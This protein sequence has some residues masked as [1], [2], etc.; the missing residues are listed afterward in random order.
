MATSAGIFPGRW[1]LYGATGYTGRLVAA[2]AVARGLPPILAGR[3]GG[4]LT[5]L[6]EQLGLPVRVFPLDEPA[7]LYAALEGVEAVLHCAGPFVWTSRPMVE[8]CLARGVHYLDVT[9]EIPVFEAILARGEEARQRGV[10]LLPGV[11]FDVVPTDCLAATLAAALP[12]GHRLELAFASSRAGWSA[13]TLKTMLE[14]LPAGGAERRDG[15][16][17][18]VRPAALTR[19]INFSHRR[20]MGVSIPWGDVSTAYHTTG[21]PNVRVYLGLPTRAALRLRRLVTLAPL[22][23]WSALRRFLQW[24]VG[25]TVQG[26]DEAARSDGRSYVWGEVRRSDGS[27]VQARLVAP[28][29]YALTAVAAVECLRRTLAGD[30]APGA[31]TPARAFG[32]AL[33]AQ[34]PGVEVEAPAVWTASSPGQAALSFVAN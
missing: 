18:A 17:V 3:S 1:L 25:R 19:R 15:R 34:L 20:L 30:V 29:G 5:A 24:W 14:L 9:G 27:W 33:A 11:G 21:I 13:G 12:G 26:P 32:A 8:A 4:P 28:E 16:I 6:G 22:L 23:R 10:A 31:W 7:A 2:E